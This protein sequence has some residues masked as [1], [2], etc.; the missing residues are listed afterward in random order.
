MS[1]PC[2]NVADV[3]AN[4]HTTGEENA[5]Y[6]KAHYGDTMKNKKNSE[7]QE[8]IETLEIPDALDDC[9]HCHNGRCSLGKSL[10]VTDG[11]VCGDYEQC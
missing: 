9:I 5:Q 4:T 7:E 2:I 3:D 1:I 8:D 11:T 10:C 6:A